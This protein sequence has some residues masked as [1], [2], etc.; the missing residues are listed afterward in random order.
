MTEEIIKRYGQRVGYPDS[1]MDVFH[2]GGHRIR[3]VKRLAA[4]A[5]HFFILHLSWMFAEVIDDSIYH[6]TIS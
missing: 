2:E 1:E 6:R 5:S 3:Q 4:G